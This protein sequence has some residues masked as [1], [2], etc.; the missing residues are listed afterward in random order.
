MLLHTPGFSETASGS[1]FQRSGLLVRPR[2]RMKVEQQ[3]LQIEGVLEL[4][5]VATPDILIGIHGVYRHQHVV[6]FAHAM[7]KLRSRVLGS[8]VKRT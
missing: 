2:I 5:G 7:W 3:W 6:S 1:D 4:Q 8:R